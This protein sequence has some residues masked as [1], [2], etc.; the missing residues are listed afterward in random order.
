MDIQDGFIVGIF[1]YC[2]RWC[3]RCPF[4]SRCRLFATLAEIEFE[5]GNGPATEPRMVRERR[6]LAT[7]MVELHARSRNSGRRRCR[8]LVNGW[9]GCR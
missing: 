1:N 2:D 5:H 7:Q 3:E 6:R 9:A 8:S 4:T